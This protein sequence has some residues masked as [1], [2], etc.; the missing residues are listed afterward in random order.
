MSDPNDTNQAT[1]LRKKVLRGFAYSVITALLIALIAGSVFVALQ[2]YGGDDNVKELKEAKAATKLAEAKKDELAEK[3]AEAETEAEENKTPKT[4]DNQSS[5]NGAPASVVKSS[6]QK[7]REKVLELNREGKG[8]F[9]V[10]GDQIGIPIRFFTG[11]SGE[12]YE[13]LAKTIVTEDGTGYTVEEMIGVGIVVDAGNKLFQHAFIYYHA[14]KEGND[15][16]DGDV[17]IAR[18]NYGSEYDEAKSQ[19]AA[20]SL[21]EA[22]ETGV[23][24]VTGN[25]PSTQGRRANEVPDPTGGAVPR[26]SPPADPNS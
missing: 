8:E 16:A 7:L 13:E 18:F 2:I 4:D 10:S 25:N 3:L 11:P 24:K 21:L 6:I 23:P 26:P 12:N 5:T 19:K 20:Q 1:S 14:K 9:F 22:I 15:L 17:G